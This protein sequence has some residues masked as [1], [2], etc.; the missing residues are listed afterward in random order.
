M[1]TPPVSIME[2]TDKQLIFDYLRGDENSF[3]DLIRRHLKSVYN[4]VYRL[5]GNAKDSEDITQEVFL[6]VWKNIK[7]YDQ[8]RGFKTWLFT[9][10]R[11][12]SIDWL[13]K[14]RNLVFSDFDNE[15][16][17]NA[18]IDELADLAP[19]PDEIFKKSE[20]KKFFD[21]LL[22]KLSPVYKE[23][24]LLRYKDQ[25]T[26]E[27]IGEILGKPLDTVKSRNRRALI[28]LRE[29]LN[30]PKSVPKSYK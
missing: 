19:L 26:F 12:T 29:L 2:K 16:G 14:K 11:N 28:V 6:K 1:I 17:G 24:L 27:E 18:I 10:A 5:A 8:D 3:R 7:R 25:F 13:R 30:A 4:F 15:E 9:I 21:E 23:V 22:N 20:D